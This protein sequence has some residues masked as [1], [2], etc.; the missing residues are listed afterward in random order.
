MADYRGYR[1]VTH[2]S[3]DAWR[4]ATIGNRYDVDYYPS[5]QPYQ[6]WDYCALLY[7]QYGRTLR[8]KA[9]GGTAADCWNYSRQYNSQT[10][11]ISL[12]GKQN[13]KRG[14]ILV[15]D[16]TPTSTTGHIGFADENYNGTNTIKLL[17]ENWDGNTTVHVANKSLSNFLGIF[18]NTLWDMTP[19]PTPPAPESTIKKRKF[20]WAV[21][22][23]H[24]DNFKN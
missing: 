6:C 9:G 22:W 8:T 5:S 7:F 24:W 14:D 19:P 15:F 11:F 17:S 1:Q 10:P 16:A 4:A 18:R 2:N 20:P 12:V 21:A 13:I 3:Y 23:A